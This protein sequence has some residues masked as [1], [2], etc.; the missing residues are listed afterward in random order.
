MFAPFFRNNKEKHYFFMSLKNDVT[1]KALDYYIL[2]I[3]FT[4]KKF[5]QPL[6]CTCYTL[7]NNEREYSHSIFQ[8]LFLPNNKVYNKYIQHI[9]I[10]N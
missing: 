2:I 9:F 8:T 4:K 10:S 6:S 1:T 3:V 7:M 5:P